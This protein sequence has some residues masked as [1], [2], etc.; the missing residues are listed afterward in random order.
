MFSKIR[1]TI[2][3]LY[4]PT[5]LRQINN[6]EQKIDDK[7]GKKTVWHQTE[8]NQLTNHSK[9]WYIFDQFGMLAQPPNKMFVSNIHL[10]LLIFV[11]WIW[12]IVAVVWSLRYWIQLCFS[13]FS[14]LVCLNEHVVRCTKSGT[15]A[16]ST[17]MLYNF[18][19]CFQKIKSKVKHIFF[20]KFHRPDI[21]MNSHLFSSFCRFFI[22]LIFR[23]Q[24]K[25]K[26]DKRFFVHCQ[27]K[28]SEMSHISPKHFRFA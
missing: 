17:Q 11:V 24:A 5:H 25:Q 15:C 18:F 28:F 2:R 19:K 8:I 10:K 12:A 9:Y 27:F 13:S 3:H 23:G 26:L 16:R 21:H 4:R 6:N 1:R 22:S 20:T 14:L 7:K